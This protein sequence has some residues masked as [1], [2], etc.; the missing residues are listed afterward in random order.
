MLLFKG[1]AAQA[2][3]ADHRQRGG[4]A[5][6]GDHLHLCPLHGAGAQVRGGSGYNNVVI[7]GV[8]Q[9]M[10]MRRSGRGWTLCGHLRDD[11]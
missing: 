6:S 7:F 4:R 3:Q 11:I 10:L 1:S 2:R 5:G 8:E 9:M